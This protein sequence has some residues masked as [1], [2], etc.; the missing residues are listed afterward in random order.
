MLRIIH[1]GKVKRESV[2]CS[3]LS[4]SLQPHQLLCLLNSSGKDTGVGFPLPSAMIGMYLILL[5]C[6]F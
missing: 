1:N 4:D 6:T 5:N 2:S 3:V